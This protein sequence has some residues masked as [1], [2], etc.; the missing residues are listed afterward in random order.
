MKL[1][2]NESVDLLYNL[3]INLDNFSRKQDKK[4]Y[5]A[6]AIQT[7]KDVSNLISLLVSFYFEFY[8]NFNTKELIKV[9]SVGEDN[10]LNAIW[11]LYFDTDNILLLKSKL[12]NLNS[13]VKFLLDQY[14]FGELIHFLSE[15]YFL[16]II[17][18]YYS[19]KRILTLIKKNSNSLRDDNTIEQYMEVDY[20][21]NSKS[22]SFPFVA[23]FVEGSYTELRYIYKKYE[24]IFTNDKK[25]KKFIRAVKLKMVAPH[26][27]VFYYKV[28]NKGNVAY[29]PLLYTTNLLAIDNFLQNGSVNVE[30]FDKPK[31]L[32]QI[33]DLEVREPHYKKIVSIKNL[34]KYYK[35]FFQPNL[36][37]S[38]EGVFSLKLKTKFVKYPIIDIWVD[39]QDNPI[40]VIYSDKKKAYKLKTRVT[41][42]LLDEGLN[43]FYVE[44]VKYYWGNTLVRGMPTRVKRGIVFTCP[45]CGETYAVDF[46]KQGL[47]RY[48][49]KKLE[50]IA[51]YH[52]DDYFELSIDKIT[53]VDIKES[54]DVNV[55]KYSIH[56]NKD[57]L[58]FKKNLYLLKPPYQ[59]LLPF[60]DLT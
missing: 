40:G 20:K 27:L 23:F 50:N 37:F 30:F 60:T 44:G 22:T 13:K 54:F 2:R 6:T 10:L 28:F 55:E 42:Q 9:R 7:N 15:D 45:L 38:N 26:F 33:K 17:P 18:T 36:C 46:C 35:M 32:Y 11:T 39:K 3:T 51:K 43:N 25:S 31:L 14:V 49:Y 1:L 29:I 19:K 52:I 41:N 59:L 5:L 34:H 56:C 8:K 48:C 47:C 57:V 4:E 21:F 16:G 58:K 53:D 12:K 24:N